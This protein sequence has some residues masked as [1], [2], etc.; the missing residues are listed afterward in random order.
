MHNSEDE[1]EKSVFT[2]YCSYWQLVSDDRW[3]VCD[4]AS[5]YNDICWTPIL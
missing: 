2:I 3:W 1:L 4:C 5:R